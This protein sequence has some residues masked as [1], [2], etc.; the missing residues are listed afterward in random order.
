MKVSAG[1]LL[2]NG[3]WP[4]A[5]AAQDAPAPEVDFLTANDLHYIDEVDQ[6]FFQK[7]VELVKQH[8]P[9]SGMLFALGDLVETADAKSHAAMRDIFKATGL[10][11][12]VV[13]GNHDWETDT[14][15]KVFDATWPNSHN[16]TFDAGGW[17]FVAVD[18]SDGTQWQNTSVPKST[19]DWVDES[20][21]K[22]DKKR[23]MIVL[24][25]FPMGEKVTYRPKNAQSLLDRFREH[26][27]RAVLCGHY[28]G[29]TERN[30][31]QTLIT[32]GKCC[33]YRRT[34]H[35]NTVDKGFYHWQTRDG[36]A[37]CQFIEVGRETP[38]VPKSGT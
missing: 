37:T 10:E 30:V 26:N 19:L 7:M 5:L 1:T 24:T 15:R 2:A 27:L 21:P 14:D 11:M 28:H 33:A 9:K 20:L 3:L 6:P 35:D 18:S 12:K 22:L 16:Y 13:C 29:Y 32:T 25:H 4:G 8:L 23:P 17:Q 38:P 31:G 34:N 36:K